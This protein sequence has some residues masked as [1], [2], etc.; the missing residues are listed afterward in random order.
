MNWI[1]PYIKLW[2]NVLCCV[3]NVATT[4][5]DSLFPLLKWTKTKEWGTRE[6]RARAKNPSFYIGRYLDCQNL[7]FFADSTSKFL[8]FIFK[9]IQNQN[10]C[11]FF[12]CIYHDEWVFRLLKWVQKDG[13]HFIEYASWISCHGNILLFFIILLNPKRDLGQN[14]FHIRTCFS[15]C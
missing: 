1:K 9:A 13:H 14:L 12:V 7:L 5:R 15:S 6:E 10:Y 3:F 11:T 8:A 2:E 4:P